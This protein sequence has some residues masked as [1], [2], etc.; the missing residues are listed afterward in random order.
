MFEIDITRLI[1]FQ[2]SIVNKICIYEI[3][4]S[5]HSVFIYILHSISLSGVVLLLLSPFAGILTAKH[6]VSYDSI[7]RPGGS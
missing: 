3:C 7:T 4:I 2:C 6:P 5:L 1:C